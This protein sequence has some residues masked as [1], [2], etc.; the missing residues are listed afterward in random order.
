MST[1][2][3]FPTWLRVEMAKR[4]LNDVGLAKMMDVSHVAVG[5]WRRGE[6]TPNFGNC[7]RLA[8]AFQLP[9]QVVLDAIKNHNSHSSRR[10]ITDLDDPHAVLRQKVELLSDEQAHA[11]LTLLEVML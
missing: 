5:H 11:V 7:V 4:D 8:R 9:E 3:D 10:P 1:E 2:L 6:R